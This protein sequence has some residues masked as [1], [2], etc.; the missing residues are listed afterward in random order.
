MS[1]TPPMKIRWKSLLAQRLAVSICCWKPIMN[2]G[3]PLVL[4]FTKNKVNA[5]TAV[6]LLGLLT[7]IPMLVK[8]FTIPV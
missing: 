4:V 8:Y 7:I 1:F 3:V 6:V 2:L 5:K